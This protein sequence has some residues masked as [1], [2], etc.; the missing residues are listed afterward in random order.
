[1]AYK[2]ALYGGSINLALIG[3]AGLILTDEYIH[4]KNVFNENIVN[5]LKYGTY[6]GGL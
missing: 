6:S 3:L 4:L 2:K 1:M 5:R